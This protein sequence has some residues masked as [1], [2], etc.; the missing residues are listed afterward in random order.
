MANAASSAAPGPAIIRLDSV[1]STQ[2]VAFDLAAGGANDGTAVMAN[3]QRCGRGRR[4]RMWQAPP[5]TSLLV[6]IVVRPTLPPPQWPSLSLAAAVALAETLA[7]VAGLHPRLKWPN[8]V[9]SHGRKLAG[10]LVESR[11]GVEAIIALGIGVNVGQRQFPD[12]LRERATSVLLESGRLVDR[13]VL[14]GAL[15]GAFARWRARLEREGFAPIRARWLELGDTV[16]RTVVTAEGEGVAVGLDEIG[17]LV[18][19]VGGERR[20]VVAGEVTEAATEGASDAA[21]H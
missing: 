1:D 3:F 12:E 5:G 17:A 6:S 7:E 20:R 21:R 11:I 10:I 19:E 15:L 2:A 18:V 9:M 13:E 14:L 8:D 4:G 16:G